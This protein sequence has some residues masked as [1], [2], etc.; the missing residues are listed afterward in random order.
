MALI[1]EEARMSKDYIYRGVKNEMVFGVDLGRGF[2]NPDRFWV[3]P[4]V[5]TDELKLHDCTWKLHYFDT[6][7]TYLAIFP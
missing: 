3:P 7:C 6:A 5:I 2:N 4:A 1:K